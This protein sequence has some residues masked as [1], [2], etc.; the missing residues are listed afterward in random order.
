MYLIL[1]VQARNRY[2]L[3]IPTIQ[4][5]CHVA[6]LKDLLLNPDRGT[7]AQREDKAFTRLVNGYSFDRG[8]DIVCTFISWFIS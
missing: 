2:E 6:G 1:P 7:H 8:A 4:G 3:W 5:P